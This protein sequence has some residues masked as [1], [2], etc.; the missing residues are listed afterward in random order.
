[1]RRT[2]FSI[3][4]AISLV[5]TATACGAPG[6]DSTDG[7][8]DP[9]SAEMV[10]PFNPGGG[11]DLAGRTIA[12]NLK[13]VGAVDRAMQITNLPG[14][15]G[16][17][18]MNK[19]EGT[20]A[21]ESNVLMTIATHVVTTPIQQG[22]ELDIA[23]MTPLA[24]MYSEYGIVAV[25][26]DSPLKSL[27]DLSESLKS[28]P[29]ATKIGGGSAGSIDEILT[30]AL[31]RELGIPPE[32]LIYIPYDGGGAVAALL[33]GNLDVMVGG[34]D[35]LD[36]I[37]A[38]EIRALGVAAP[39]QLAGPLADIPTFKDQGLDIEVA[40]WRGVFGPKDM[41]EAAGRYW[42][43]QLKKVSTSTAWKG[44]LEKNNFIDDFQADGFS[45]FIVQQDTEFREALL[46][47]TG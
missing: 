19:M 13:D 5:A 24:R 30:R 4:A 11:V 9:G 43:E 15:S 39:E 23:R 12:Q 34:F 25:A 22:E 18:G 6:S 20:Y 17:I 31:G 32:D 37:K 45:D 35:F 33:G 8:F 38:G 29:K 28:D 2:I 42:K 3:I 21:G 14:G 36:L 40:N 27:T 1:M 41:P 10:I 46:G 7:A 47:K 26:K 44:F 16:G